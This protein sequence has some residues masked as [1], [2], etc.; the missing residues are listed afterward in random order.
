MRPL[1]AQL[2]DRIIPHGFVQLVS[3]AT[4]LSQHQEPSGLDHFYSNHPEKLS[5]IQAHYRGSSD[6]KIIF[7]TRFT[8]SAVS[9]PRIIRKRSFKDFDSNS[10]KEAIKNTS[11]WEVYCCENVEEAVSLMTGK[12]N[13]ILD[14][15]APIK[16]IQV[17]TKFAPWMSENTKSKIKERDLAQKQAAESRSNEDWAEFKILRNNVNSRL[18]SEKKQWQ[19]KKLNE[20]GNDSSTVWKNIKNWLG[21]GKGGPPTKLKENGNLCSKPKDIARILNELFITKVKNL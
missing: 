7:G 20:F 4:R 10:F 3:V 15:M 19:E 6:H 1:I 11:W 5:D 9:K 14:E 2:F 16:T 18:K 21:W 17:H 8:K 12:I 13:L